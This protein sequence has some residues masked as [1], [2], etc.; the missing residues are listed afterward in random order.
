M[1]SDVQPTSCV[2]MF[3]ISPAQSYFSGIIFAWIYIDHCD[4]WGCTCKTC[5]IRFFNM[6]NKGQELVLFQLFQ[7]VYHV[8]KFPEIIPVV[9]N[10][11]NK[12]KQESSGKL[13]VYCSINYYIFTP[14]LQQT[15]WV[16]GRECFYPPVMSMKSCWGWG[17]G[18][19][20]LCQ[21]TWTK[22]N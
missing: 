20:R 19:F 12:N 2:M 6:A 5:K 17:S 7:T 13:K 11:C 22:Q 9:L 15:Q 14:R 10:W 21:M 1:S 3:I 16:H 4:F 8:K 18:A